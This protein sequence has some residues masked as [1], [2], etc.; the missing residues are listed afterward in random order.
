MTREKIKSVLLLLTISI[1]LVTRYM[2]HK[3]ISIAIPVTLISDVA[4]VILIVLALLK[5]NRHL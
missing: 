2:E 1:L 4:M 5:S 3:N